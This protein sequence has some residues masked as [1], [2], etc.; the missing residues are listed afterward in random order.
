MQVDVRTNI[1]TK[2]VVV[3]DH[4]LVGEVL[5][6][7]LGELGYDTRSLKPECFDDAVEC[8][9]DHQADVVL[10]DLDLG[11]LGLSIPF[12]SRLRSLGARVVMVTGETSRVRLGSCIEAGA[13]AVVTKGSSFE[14]LLEQLRAILEGVGDAIHAEREEMLA[15][16]RM[17]REAE[18]ERLRPL[19]RLTAREREVLSDLV[20]G[21]A[22]NEI[23]ERRFVSLTTVRTHI[24]AI[25]RKLDVKSQLAAVA[26]ARRSDWFG[27]E[28]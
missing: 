12:I 20:C 2:V 24:R 8:V 18:R 27:P 23:A 10:L 21:L 19:D 16:L 14:D 4:A 25:L 7:A 9:V 6:H 5:A 26:L 17:H 22:A 28:E 1:A 11:A 3:D 13:D 15:S